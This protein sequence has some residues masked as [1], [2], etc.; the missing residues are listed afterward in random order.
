MTVRP[1]VPEVT[2]L[3]TAARVV[4]VSRHWLRRQV[5]DGEL[6]SYRTGLRTIRVRVHDVRALLERQIF[7]PDAHAQSV[8]AA[9]LRRE[10]GR[11]K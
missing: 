5:E 11:T 4:G 2:S 7:R 10:A 6:A 9:R 1:T 3:R 8:V